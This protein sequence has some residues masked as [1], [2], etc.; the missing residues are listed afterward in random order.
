M[1][2]KITPFTTNIQCCNEKVMINYIRN[3]IEIESNVI[4][5]PLPI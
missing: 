2:K 4:N 1:K 5:E 3:R